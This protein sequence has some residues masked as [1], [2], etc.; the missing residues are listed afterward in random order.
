MQSIST[1]LRRRATEEVRFNTL[2]YN[3]GKRLKRECRLVAR[4]FV[5]DQDMVN[6][7]RYALGNRP[8]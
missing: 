4:D 1:P 5:E 6:G 7:Y 2:N 3:A 8:G